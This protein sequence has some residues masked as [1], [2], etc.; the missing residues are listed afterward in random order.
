MAVITKCPPANC[1]EAFDRHQ[2]RAHVKLP[3]SAIFVG[4]NN[5]D[6]VNGWIGTGIDFGSYERMQTTV[7]NK[8]FASRRVDV[9]EFVYNEHLLR[10]VIVLY[11][12]SR[13]TWVKF[14][15]TTGTLEERC[16]RAVNKIQSEIPKLER[17]CN[18][19]CDAYAEVK[20]SGAPAASP[21]ASSATH[22]DRA[23]TSDDYS[24]DCTPDAAADMSRLEKQI[25]ECDSQMIF[26]ARPAAIT[27][28][29]LQHYFLLG[30][31]SADTAAALGL[32]A[33]GVR[34]ILRRLLSIAAADGMKVEYNLAH[35]Y[36]KNID[37]SL[38]CHCKKRQRVHGKTLCIPCR[39]ASRASAMASYNRRKKGKK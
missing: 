36:N 14:K 23:K 19:L 2:F 5:P 34:Q 38:C 9:P 10:R 28:G 25:I 18:I 16:A 21:H 1:G 4:Q 35:G 26:C 13:G 29:I 6:A 27:V 30:E 20:R 11:L 33:C 7:H 37:P 8:A 3:V 22:R 17:R 15:N 24:F 12:E 39:D 31:K 32:S